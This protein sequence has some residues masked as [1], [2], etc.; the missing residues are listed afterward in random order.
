MSE[1]FEVGIGRELAEKIREHGVETYPYECCG[2]LLGQDLGL[3]ESAVSDKTSHGVSREVLSLFPLVNRRDDSPRNRF[4]VT[5]E[6]V[7]D[8]EKTAKAQGLEVI[9]WYHS[10]PDH[11]ARPSEYDRDH[12]WPWYSYIIVSVH[13][14]VPQDMTSWRLKDDRSEFLEEKIAP[15]KVSARN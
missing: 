11:P 2:A 14:G 12:A 13:S 10:H 9:G 6:D 1:G 15:M 5:A 3:R 4:S 7:R 8:A